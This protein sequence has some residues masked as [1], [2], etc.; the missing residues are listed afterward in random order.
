MEHGVRTAINIETG[1][2]YLKG[3]E[4]PAEE[5]IPEQKFK[6]MVSGDFD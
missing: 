4:P 1:H 2:I 3:K 5:E 6:N